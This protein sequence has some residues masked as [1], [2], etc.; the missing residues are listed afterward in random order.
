MMEEIFEAL[1]PYI[2]ELLIAILT[3][4]AGWIAKKF[5]EKIKNE[6]ARQIIK[7]SVKYAE[8]V[9]KTLG[10]SEKYQI[11]L[12]K[13]STLLSAKGIK[14]SADEIETLVEAFV[15]EFKKGVE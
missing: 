3:A 9:G 1:K 11:A 15:S 8:Q 10:G 12:D 2:I 5:N 13:I 14:M 4:V 6:R 7:D